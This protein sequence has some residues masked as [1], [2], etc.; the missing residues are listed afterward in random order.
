MK[1][2]VLAW[3]FPAGKLKQEV[4]SITVVNA[5]AKTVDTTVPTGK[6]WILLAVKM[7]NPD[8]VARVGVITKWKEAAKTNRLKTYISASISAGVTNQFPSNPANTN[9]QRYPSNP[10]E[11]LMAGNTIEVTWASGG[12]STGGTD[13]DGLVIEYLEIDV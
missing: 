11:M 13:A 3:T 12:A 8:D 5:T 6:M 2:Q 4:T 9:Q 1:D 10:A 7:V